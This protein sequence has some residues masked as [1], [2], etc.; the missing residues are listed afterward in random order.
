MSIR[1]A[2]SGHGPPRSSTSPGV[3]WVFLVGTELGG[4]SRSSLKEENK[5]ISGGLFYIELFQHEAQAGGS[6]EVF[7][8]IQ[9]LGRGASARVWEAGRGGRMVVME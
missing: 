3:I 6:R 1:G 5:A 2:V 8:V 9:H 7:A 4:A